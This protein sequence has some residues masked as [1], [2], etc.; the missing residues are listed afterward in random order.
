MAGREK[1][2]VQL[3]LDVEWALEHASHTNRGMT[4]DVGR[5]VCGAV[6]AFGHGNHGQAVALLEPVRDIAARFGG[7]HA[8]RDALTL[9]LIEAAIRDGQHA[10]ARHYITERLVF[11]LTS[12]WGRRLEIRAEGR[13][14]GPSR[15]VQAA[16]PA[17]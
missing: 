13:H 11:K 16:M 7:S 2:A 6:R 17:T 9:T 8:Q 1:E 14:Q 5:A 12:R 4:R 10:L 15:H 3:T